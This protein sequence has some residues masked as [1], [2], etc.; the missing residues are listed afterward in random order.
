MSGK[1]LALLTGI[2]PPV[3]KSADL[4]RVRNLPRR[5]RV[6]PGTA[7]AEALIEHQT[8][9]YTRGIPAGSCGCERIF[10]EWKVQP[11]PC[12]TRLN[13]A[14]AWMLHELTL[15]AGLMA[16]A[17]TGCGKT[18]VNILAP[19]AMPDCKVAVLLIP[20]TLAEQLAREWELL[21]QHFKV[22]S[23]YIHHKVGK[24]K[25]WVKP[26][27]GTPLLHVLPYSQL[28]HPK[29]TV[30][31]ESFLKPD[32]IFADECQNLASLGSVRTG[33]LVRLF[34]Q[35]KD[36]LRMGTWSGSLTD[37]EIQDMSTLSAW[38]LKGNS[39]LPLYP[40]T[41][42]EWGTALNPDDWRAPGGALIEAFCGP[43]ED[44]DE[45]YHRRLAETSGFVITSG[46][47]VDTPLEVRER[48]APEMPDVPRV[49]P[50]APGCPGVCEPGNWPGVKTALTACRELWVRPDGEILL[51]AL[52]SSRCARELAVGLFLKWKFIR[53]ETRP[54]IQ[55]W[56]DK[57]KLWRQE[58]REKLKE[59]I[60]HMDSPMLLANA[61]MR[62]WG[63]KPG[64]N[65]IVDLDE[66][67]EPILYTDDPSLPYWKAETWPDWY[68]VKQT[69]QPVTEAVRLDPFLATDAALWAAEN[70]GIVWYYN[71]AFGRWVAELGGLPLHDGGPKAGQRL[72]RETGD[73]SIICSIKSHGTGRD[74]LQ[75][76]FSTQ[77]VAQPPSSAVAFEQL[78]GRLSRIGQTADLVHAYLYRHTD[79]IQKCV[80]TA[81]RKSLYVQKIMNTPQRLIVGWTE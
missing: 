57:R 32:T 5:P 53:G 34:E 39:P 1:P 65:G 75:R 76:L 14:Q 23:I 4:T 19:L 27:P 47:S 74:G 64:K 7:T 66:E 50:L 11:K 6:E 37:D 49:D 81:M 77:L 43:D 80:D 40:R 29:A 61:A 35:M 73:R 42:D 79:E 9:K 2:K 20:P 59:K 17:A 62:A 16:H 68:A 13:Y 48:T 55:I 22:S 46:A 58:Q 24:K 78:F 25:E 71:S 52:Q 8:A 28:S 51:D 69:V 41:A 54:E 3:G 18:V 31:L 72:S 21:D 45:G 67:G 33:R 36:T 44:V 56:R 15:N 60:P 10:R 38:S 26:I 30:Y 63:H 12:I 70:R